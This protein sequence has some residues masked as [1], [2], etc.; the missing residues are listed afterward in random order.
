MCEALLELVDIVSSVDRENKRLKKEIFKQYNLK[1][2]QNG[3]LTIDGPKFGT[4]ETK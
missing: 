3:K 1:A 2:I 4:I